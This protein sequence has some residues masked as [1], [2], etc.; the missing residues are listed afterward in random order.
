VCLPHHSSYYFIK[1]ESSGSVNREGHNLL[2]SE[3]SAD[4]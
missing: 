3:I 2:L 1:P 4:M